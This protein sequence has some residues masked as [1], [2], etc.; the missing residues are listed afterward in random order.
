M[1]CLN[2]PKGEFTIVTLVHI[3]FVKSNIWRFHYQFFDTCIICNCCIS[4]WSII[5]KYKLKCQDHVVFFL[6]AYIKMSLF[7]LCSF[8]IE[9]DMSASISHLYTNIIMAGWCTNVSWRSAIFPSNRTFIG[10][11]IVNTCT[12]FI[13][14]E[15]KLTNCVMDKKWAFCCIV[16]VFKSI[17]VWC[18]VGICFCLTMYLYCKG[19]SI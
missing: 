7:E 14:T 11:E 16:D 8:R 5:S 17:C 1:C 19:T 3:Y 6:Q 13:H 4:T 15:W 18:N 10:L 9:I 2:I 12:Y